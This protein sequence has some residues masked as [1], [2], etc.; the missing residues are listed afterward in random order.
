VSWPE[1]DVAVEAAL[2]AGAAGARMI[3]GGFGGSVLALAPSA[4]L[5]T[6]RDAITSAFAE[7]A[8]TAP[9]FLSATPADAARRIM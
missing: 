7:H 5:N 2:A 8:W 3:G 4:S 9:E 6:V 1:A